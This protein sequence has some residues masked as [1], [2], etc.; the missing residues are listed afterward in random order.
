MKF[1]TTRPLKFY[2][3]S[4]G[5]MWGT[6]VFTDRSTACLRKIMLGR[7][8]PRMEIAKIHKERGALNEALYGKRLAEEGLEYVEEE[9]VKRPIGDTGVLLSGR[10]DFRVKR[11]EDGPFNVEELKSTES[12]NVHRTVI[13][14]RKLYPEN[15]AQLISYMIDTESEKGRLI[16]TYYKRNERGELYHPEPYVNKRKNYVETERIFEVDID[17]FGRVHVDGEASQWT[18]YDV[19]A[20]RFAAADVI[21]NNRVADR[22]FNHDA[23]WGSP[24]EYCDF[25]V[26]CE[27]WDK[28]EI[29]DEKSFIEEARS[30]LLSKKG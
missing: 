20:H 4:A 1:V 12:D 6:V 9:V 25:R 22:P 8:M 3:S 29:K 5:F 23:V 21:K 30:E 19:L 13:R 24:C 7:H 27:R 11:E 14:N 16:Y 28:D 26:T 18:V 17:E 15:L 2:P 10:A